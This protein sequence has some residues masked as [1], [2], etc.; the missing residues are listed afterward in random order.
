MTS[1]GGGGAVAALLV[2]LLL[3][4]LLVCALSVSWKSDSFFDCYFLFL[5][6][7]FTLLPLWSPLDLLFCFRLHAFFWVL[8]LSVSGGSAPPVISVGDAA[9]RFVY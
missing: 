4:L 2:V 8:F 7:C 5:F 9:Q 1:G 3:V 6:F